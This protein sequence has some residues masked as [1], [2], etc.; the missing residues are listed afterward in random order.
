MKNLKQYIGNM[1]VIFSEVRD[2]C[3]NHNK[4]IIL[5]YMFAHLF[6]FNIQFNLVYYEVKTD[7]QYELTLTT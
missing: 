7:I 4:T 2:V 6:P 5:E 3:Q 1:N